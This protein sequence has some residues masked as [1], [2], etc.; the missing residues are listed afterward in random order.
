M[1][2]RRKSP[3]NDQIPNAAIQREGWKDGKMEWW[4]DVVCLPREIISRKGG[5]PADREFAI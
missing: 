2:G 3:K 4:K 1:P 5:E